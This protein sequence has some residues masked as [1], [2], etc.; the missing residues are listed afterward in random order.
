MSAGAADS[1]KPQ[2]AARAAPSRPV[3]MLQVFALAAKKCRFHA[4]RGQDANLRVA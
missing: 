3:D 2:I 4:P 1:P